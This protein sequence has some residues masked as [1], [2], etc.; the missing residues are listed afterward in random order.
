MEEIKPHKTLDAKGLLCPMP[1]MKTNQVIKEIQIGQIL[2]VIATDPASK[3]DISA[4][5][6][7]T[8]NELLKM[9]EEKGHPTVY[10]FYIKRLR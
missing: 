4:W 5:C 10:R 8:G 3:S 1:V 7:Q 9:I 6:K 2:E